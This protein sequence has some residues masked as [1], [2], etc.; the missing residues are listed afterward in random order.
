MSRSDGKYAVQKKDPL[1]AFYPIIG[2]IIFAIAVAV[3]WFSAPFVLEFGGDYIP[4]EALTS[5]SEL[6]PNAPLYTVAFLIFLVIIM[7]FSAIYAVF[8][9]KPKIQV[10]EASLKRERDSKAEERRRAKLR[11]RKMRSR[12]KAANKDMDDI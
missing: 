12:M 1:A 6:D 2:L 7:S 5:L 11:K 10:S 9:P 8:A 4:A 3:G